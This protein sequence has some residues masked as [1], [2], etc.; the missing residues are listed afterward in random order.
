MHTDTTNRSRPQAPDVRRKWPQAGSNATGLVFIVCGSSRPAL[1]A[2]GMANWALGLCPLEAAFYPG[3]NA[4]ASCQPRHLDYS[5]RRS[6]CRRGGRAAEGAR[7][8]SVYTGNRIEGSNPSPSARHCSHPIPELIKALAKPF[9]LNPAYTRP[10]PV[11][12]GYHAGYGSGDAGY[13]GGPH[14]N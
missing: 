10:Y 2:T 12:S 1:P 13:F 6:G 5:A 3:G 14:A 4:T 9:A 7:L 11:N 8:E